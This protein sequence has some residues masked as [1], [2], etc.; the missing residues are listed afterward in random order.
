MKKIS[1]NKKWT[2][3]IC[4]ILPIASIIYISLT[5]IIPRNASSFLKRPILEQQ[6]VTQLLELEKPINK[7]LRY[8]LYQDIKY[9]KLRQNWYKKTITKIAINKEGKI[10]GYKINNIFYPNYFTK[11][12]I[13]NI[14]AKSET[15]PFKKTNLYIVRI[16]FTK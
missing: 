5:S 14:I 16:N 2:N 3:I 4:N 7:K 12:Q 8:K 1:T 9:H 15:F 11:T 10:I 6:K 13:K